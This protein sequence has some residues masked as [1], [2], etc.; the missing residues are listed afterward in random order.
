MD[1]SSHLISQLS[2]SQK[3]RIL[4]IESALLLV[5]EEGIKSLNLTKL[6][7]SSGVS[8]ALIRY[9]FPDLKLIMMEIFKVMAQVGQSYTVDHIS[10]AKSPKEELSAMIL[11]AFLWA[12][13]YPAYCQFITIMYHEATIDPQVRKLHS[14][15]LGAGLVRLKTIIK[16]LRPKLKQ[17]QVLHLAEGIQNLIMASILR[18]ATFNDFDNYDKYLDNTEKLTQLLIKSKF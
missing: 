8:K 3:K 10:K 2:E 18:M 9:H 17:P 15:I 12:R 6:S 14:Q 4:I 1:V 13:D 11:A 16:N 7:K 5:T